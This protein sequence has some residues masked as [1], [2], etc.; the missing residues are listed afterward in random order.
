MADDPWAEF[1]VKQP[2]APADAPPLEE[3][4]PEP[5]DATLYGTPGY[6]ALDLAAALG[7]LIAGRVDERSSRSDL[8]PSR[9]P[10]L[11]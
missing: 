2:P 7:G 6:F 11:H 3:M 4:T 10:T 5:L 9:S 8:D 1:R